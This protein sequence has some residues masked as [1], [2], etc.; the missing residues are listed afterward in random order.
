MPASGIT[1]TC[2]A[3]ERK[4]TGEEG[5]KKERR[6]RGREKGR[7]REGNGKEKEIKRKV[8]RKREKGK[9]EV[10]VDQCA[11]FM[12][13]LQHSESLSNT[14]SKQTCSKLNSHH[15]SVITPIHSP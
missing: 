14:V 9:R 11:H 6:E 1:D 5:E 12:E 7:K 2:R 4:G 13:S 10:G 3:E 15:S 8:K